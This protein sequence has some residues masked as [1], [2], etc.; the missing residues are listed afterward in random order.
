MFDGC[1]IRVVWGDALATDHGVRLCDNRGE[2]LSHC[3]PRFSGNTTDCKARYAQDFQS[4]IC[5]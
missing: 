4:G 2:V 5:S 1:V 3:I